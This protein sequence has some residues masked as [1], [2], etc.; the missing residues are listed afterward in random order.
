M[1]ELEQEFI[2]D[3]E[4]VVLQYRDT[5]VKQ[6]ESD[7]VLLAD[8]FRELKQISNSQQNNIDLIED[9]VT[10]VSEKF[11]IIEEELETADKYHSK[12][13]RKKRNLSL[14]GLVLLSPF[15]GLKYGIA[16]GV[17]S[18]AGLMYV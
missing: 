18:V 2:F 13:N 9:N 7:V 5:Q 3:E 1:T 14:F 4:F 16:V 10:D 8:L 6:L 17:I 11:V 15:M 12:I